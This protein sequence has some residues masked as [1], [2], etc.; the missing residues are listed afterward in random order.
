LIS[1]NINDGIFEE[2]RIKVLT[3]TALISGT[4]LDDGNW[5]TII[6]NKKDGNNAD[7]IVLTI[8]G[9]NELCRLTVVNISFLQKV[10][11]TAVPTAALNAFGLIDIN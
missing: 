5:G 6:T 7:V 9:D 10:N 1:I 4:L 11:F 8:T 3:E 2:E